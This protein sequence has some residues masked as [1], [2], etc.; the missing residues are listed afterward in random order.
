MADWVFFFLDKN[1]VSVKKKVNTISAN[2]EK[3]PIC[4]DIIR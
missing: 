3:F 4:S 1:F 2:L